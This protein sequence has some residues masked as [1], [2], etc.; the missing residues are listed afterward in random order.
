MS[1]TGLSKSVGLRDVFGKTAPRTRDV[2]RVDQEF[3]FRQPKG[4]TV[5]MGKPF[6]RKAPGSSR[7]GEWLRS[8]IVGLLLFSVVASSIAGAGTALFCTVIVA[9]AVFPLLVGSRNALD[10]GCVF[11]LVSL[12]IVV[13][14]DLAQ[15]G[16][17]GPFWEFCTLSM[18]SR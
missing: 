16:V 7:P 3:M 15:Y 10:A 1:G 5:R 17:T 12:G 4:L 6:E 18:R 11:M 9:W 8:G 2:A 14:V 13:V